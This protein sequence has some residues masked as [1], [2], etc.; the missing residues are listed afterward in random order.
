MTMKLVVLLA[1]VLLPA[2]LLGRTVQ[3]AEML[4]F[5]PQV[6]TSAADGNGT[7]IDLLRPP[8]TRSS[9]CRP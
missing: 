3:A 4:G 2:A 7:A 1:V 5:A 8:G 6:L 9:C